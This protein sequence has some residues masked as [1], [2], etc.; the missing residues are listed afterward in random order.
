ML[1]ASPRK[2]HP[3]KPDDLSLFSSIKKLVIDLNPAR[4]CHIDGT[5]LTEVESERFTL[6]RGDSLLASRKL[7][8]VWAFTGQ[9]PGDC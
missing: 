1:V 3:C 2:A 6:S 5:S 7:A 9:S 8:H 4:V